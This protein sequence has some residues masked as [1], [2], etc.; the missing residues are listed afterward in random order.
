MGGSRSP[1]QVTYQEPEPVHRTGTEEAR[2]RDDAQ[3]RA[4]R[5][6]G[7]F[8]TDITRSGATA[9]ASK[10]RTLGGDG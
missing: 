5:S 10:K 7:V 2:I 8:G 6:F 1:K 4:A 3:A 9:P